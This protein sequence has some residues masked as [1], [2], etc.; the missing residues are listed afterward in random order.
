MLTKYLIRGIHIQKYSNVFLE[1]HVFFHVGC[2][3]LSGFDQISEA[4][5]DTGTSLTEKAEQERKWSQNVY[6]HM[7][8]VLLCLTNWQVQAVSGSRN[9]ERENAVSVSQDVCVCVCVWERERERERE[10]ER[11][12]ESYRQS[13]VYMGNPCHVVGSKCAGQNQRCG[14][15]CKHKSRDFPEQ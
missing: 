5:F 2:L 11:Q 1:K 13:L 14:R 15:S 7:L 10:T 12:R 8:R 4:V 9:E 6:A 3:S